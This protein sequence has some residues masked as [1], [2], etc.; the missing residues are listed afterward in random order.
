MESQSPGW[1][2]KSAGEANARYRNECTRYRVNG[3]PGVKDRSFDALQNART[4]LAQAQTDASQ[5]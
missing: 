4:W 3:V 1:M 2:L 5:R